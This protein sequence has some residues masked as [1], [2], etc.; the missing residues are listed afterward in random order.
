VLLLDALRRLA[1]YAL[2]IGY[3]LLSSS[4]GAPMTLSRGHELVNKVE[5]ELTELRVALGK[6]D[7]ELTENAMDKLRAERD[8]HD[9]QLLIKYS[10]GT[11]EKEIKASS[12][13]ARHWLAM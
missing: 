6:I 5:K 2:L 4:W 8:L 13:S 1:F 7:Q 12:A 11:V 9:A 10:L 3:F